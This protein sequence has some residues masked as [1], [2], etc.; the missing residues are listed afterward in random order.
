MDI[1]K[2]MSQADQRRL[3]WQITE[4]YGAA[5]QHTRNW[6]SKVR[7][8]AEE[9]LLPEA[10][11]EDRIKDR[12][13]LQNLN[14]RLSVFVAD[15]LQVTNVPMNWKLGKDTA[16]NC[17]KVF[18]SNFRTM[19]MREKYR[20]VIYDDW[21]Y[22]VG[23]MAVDGW[24]DHT[25]EPILSYVDARLC[26]ADPSNW[27]DSNLLF[28]GTKV[29]K[30]YWE[31]K[32][33]E[34]YDINQV[35]RVK[36]T[37]DTEQTQVNRADGNVKWFTDVANSTNMIELYN[38][39]TI[40]KEEGED[41]HVYLTTLWADRSQFVRIVKIRPINE[42]E[43][44]DPSKIDLGVKLFR[45]KPLKWSFAWVSLIDDLGQYQDLLT[46]FT[47]LQTEQAKEAALWGRTFVDTLLGVDLDDVWD[48][49][50]A[51]E[52][53]P[54][55]SEN[56]VV[57][58]NGIFQQPPRQ[59]SPVVWNQ[60][61]RLEQ[62]KQQADPA[63][64][65]LATGVGTPWSQ[66]K[67][68]IQTLQQNI[69]QILS[70]M[71]S[72]YMASLVSLWESVYKSYARN[73]SSQRRKEIV[74]VDS[75]SNP[76]K[77]GFKKNEFISNGDVYILVTSK[78]EQEAK[79]EKQYAQT[80][81]FY[82]SISQK[83]DPKSTESKILDRYLMEKSNSWIDPTIIISYTADERQAYDD[84]E[85]LNNDEKADDPIA[86]QDH[87]AFINI[88]KTWLQTPARELAIIN[89]EIMIQTES[90]TRPVAP[91]EQSGGWMAAQ[92][93]ASMIAS[94]NA[95]WQDPSLS[96]I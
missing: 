5:E 53:I 20:D 36:L 4:E 87:N 51:W 30:S 64:T 34:A 62:L 10:T 72:N 78:R 16:K 92:M 88:Y 67:A 80:L 22:W 46:L 74:V 17:N 1:N 43:K 96:T 75:Q 82:G 2:V 7:N 18:Q 59:I 47:N 93:G 23:A 44:A 71:Q 55:T 8:V 89:R 35:E 9:Y 50:G 54:Y 15:D 3:L 27:Q 76:D 56:G 66:T 31:L 69:N 48:W 11:W 95:Q 52:I 90:T 49:S 57:A 70:Y 45:G 25:Q 91:V 14:I 63:S 79:N 37:I 6:R 77:Y 84:L 39:I 40:F 61:A 28:F 26:Y 19:W 33:D 29:K 13:V 85:L 65:S 68:E 83:L 60:V 58:A 24:N 32:N 21:L 38:H 86:G 41:A 73:M 81:S 94:D 42:W 12:S